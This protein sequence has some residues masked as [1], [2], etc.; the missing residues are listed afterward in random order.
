MAPLLRKLRGLAHCTGVTIIV[1]HHQNKSGGSRGSGA[2][3]GAGDTTWSFSRNDAKPAEP[4]LVSPPRGA[5]V[6]E[7]R[8]IPKHEIVIQF[9]SDGRWNRA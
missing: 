5:L 9:G 6:V 2:I 8:R 4:G 3:P 7:G 1:N